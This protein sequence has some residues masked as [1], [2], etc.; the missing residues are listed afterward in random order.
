MEP[1]KYVFELTYNGVNA[2]RE[3]TPYLSSANYTDAI[4]ESDTISITLMD[5]DGKWMPS[6]PA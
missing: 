1:R 5:R 3:I 4:D 6:Q 2:T